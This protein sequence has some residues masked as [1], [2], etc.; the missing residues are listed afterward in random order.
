MENLKK[1]ASQL[2]LFLGLALIV[3]TSIAY[4][5]DLNLFTKWWYGVGIMFLVVSFGCV[6]AVRTKKA[7][8]GFLGFKETFI[9]Y[10]ITVVVGV[11]IYT[12]YSILLFNVIDPEAKD[13]ITENV[14]KYTIDMMQ[15]F[16]AKPADINKI[17]EDMKNT[18]NFGFVGQAKGLIWNILIYSVIGL[19]AALIIKREKPQSF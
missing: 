15:G 8:G 3:L 4:A 5:V 1:I 12:A 7:A 14:I 2:G 19:I 6:A 10:F 18:D 16:G 9:S 11:A 13:I 17:V